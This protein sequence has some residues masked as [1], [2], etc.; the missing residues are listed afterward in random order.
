MY[1]QNVLGEVSEE[2]LWGILFLVQ[3]QSYSLLLN[4]EMS[5]LRGIFRDFTWILGG[6]LSFLLLLLFLFSLFFFFF[7]LYF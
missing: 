3:L 5:P 2:C 4:W 1:F 7:Y 6:F